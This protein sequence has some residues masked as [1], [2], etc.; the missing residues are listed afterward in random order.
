M[1][2]DS[3]G[4][5]GPGGPLSGIRVIDVSS[6][7]AGPFAGL[8]LADLGAEV[9][10][11]EPVRGDPT[12]R[13]GG[14]PGRTS[15]MAAAVNRNKRSVGLTL[16]D[17]RGRS[18][19]LG[20]ARDADVFL[21]NWRPSTQAKL[22]LT[23]DVLEAA[24]PRLVRVAISGYGQDSVHAEEPAFDPIIQ[25]QCGLFSAAGRDE[26]P[27]AVNMIIADK[28]ASLYTVQGVLAALHARER[29]GFGD[30]VTVPM[31][32]SLAYFDFPDLLEG[33]M[34][35]DEPGTGRRAEAYVAAR[36]RDG[37][38]VIAPTTGAQIKRTL[39]VVG[40]PEWRD[41]LVRYS[42]RSEFLRALIDLIEPE[43]STAP[44]ATWLDRFGQADVPAAPVVDVA[45][46]LQDQHVV[47]N[48]VYQEYRHP[49]RGRVRAARY[50]I[51]FA[52]H[53][54]AM[55]GPYPEAGQ[56]NTRLLGPEFAIQDGREPDQG[57]DG[58]S[59]DA[60]DQPG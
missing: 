60:V 19:L 58:A 12:R 56:D 49:E 15:P 27:T 6:Y 34:F 47:H 24:Q 16:S 54:P 14:S 3:I 37:Y 5:N 48:Q 30:L 17:P 32:D 35:I 26:R 33:E 44:V 22:G 50:P 57:A 42:D 8:M 10:K 46:H 40:H 43:L 13:I 28:I 23:D 53:L 21:H 4:P 7:V 55:A 2:D 25:A 29:T 41:Q 1:N 39:E 51:R 36:A 52:G 38:L 11:V 20:L 59:R 45:G 9:I 18:A 31:L